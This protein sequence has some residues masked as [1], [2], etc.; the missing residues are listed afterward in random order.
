MTLES[1]GKMR[2][3][4]DDNFFP[5]CKPWY[6][7]HEIADEIQDE[8]ESRFM[9]LPL[10]A[11]GVPIHVNDEVKFHNDAPVTVMSIG[12]SQVYGLNDC[13]FYGRAGNFFGHGTL[14]NIRHIK[15]RTVED[16]LRDCCNEWNQH[17]GED[18]EHGVYAKYA[19]ELRMRDG[20]D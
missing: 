18:W 12:M 2:N 11:D 8:I 1:L 3:Y 5:Q 14:K 17:C 7:G 10:D 13:G 19:A 16:V 15:P 6:E 20:D 9:E 4:I